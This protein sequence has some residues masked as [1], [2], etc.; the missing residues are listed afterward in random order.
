MCTYF[1]QPPPYSEPQSLVPS[2]SPS[3]SRMNLSEAPSLSPSS[4]HSCFSC[5]PPHTFCPCSVLSHPLPVTTVS[6]KEQ[7]R[8]FFPLSGVW[9]VNLIPLSLSQ[10]KWREEV[11]R[12]EVGQLIL[13]WKFL[14]FIK[15]VL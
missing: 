3:T 2:S 1:I 12:V 11:G 9:F 5:L 13:L 7:L 15:L 4:S 14:L 8:H 6:P 10:E